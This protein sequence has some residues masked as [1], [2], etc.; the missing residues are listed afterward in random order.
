LINQDHLNRLILKLEKMLKDHLVQ[1]L[2]GKRQRSR[3]LETEE[4][5]N[6]SIAAEQQE[7]HLRS[8]KSSDQV[9]RSIW[10]TQ[11]NCTH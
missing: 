5:L 3:Y 9:W 4:G 10:A 11:P 8:L 1:F 6:Q 2:C 7:V